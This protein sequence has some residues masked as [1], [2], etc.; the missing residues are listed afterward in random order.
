MNS[1]FSI[2]NGNRLPNILS[3]AKLFPRRKQQRKR[4]LLSNRDEGVLMSKDNPTSAGKAA[5]N[6]TAVADENTGPETQQE[7]P[8]WKGLYIA[9]FVLASGAVMLAQLVPSTFS[10][11]IRIQQLAPDAKDVMLPIALTVPAA[12]I[13]FVN[14][15]VG[16]LSDTTR[17]RFGRRR[18]W[19]VGGLLVGLIGMLTIA[20]SPNVPLVVVGWTV[21]YLGLTTGSAMF[22]THMGDRLPQSQRGIVAGINGSLVQVA[23]I[24]GI[25]VSGRLVD[26]AVL[27]FTVPALIAIVGALPFVLMINDPSTKDAEVVARPS[28]LGIFKRMVFNP[29]KHPDLGWVW[30]SKLCV[31]VAL[32]CNSVYSVYFLQER[33]GLD[34]GAVAAL[35]A[36]VGGVSIIFAM[37]GAFLGGWISDKIGKRKVL[38]YTAGAFFAV[39]LVVIAFTQNTMTYIIGSVLFTIGSGI[40]GSVDQAL[41]LDVLP[42]R[43]EA[44]RWIAITALANEIPKALSPI[45]AGTLVVLGGGYMGVYFLSAAFALAGC[46][47]VIPIKKAR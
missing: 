44:G 2:L 45:L 14:P 28:I 35:V 33:L 19:I 30:I 11:A 25:L 9:L 46:L 37:G 17:S 26:S 12:A 18:P 6:A 24:I 42:S 16:I 38:I 34:A 20:F 4:V 31:F 23:P 27:L 41:S 15:V 47:L 22:A 40:F 7:L 8:K 32:Y 29:K 10:L 21:G 36:T 13:I 43:D 3:Y 39:G 1:R 5:E